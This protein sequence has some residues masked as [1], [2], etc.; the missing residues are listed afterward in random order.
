MGNRN[1]NFFEVVKSGDVLTIDGK[2]SDI[3]NKEKLD[4]IAIEVNAKNQ[5]DVPV[6][7]GIYTFV[8][9]KS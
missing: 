4:V 3:K 5:N 1:L 2:I 8:V 9:R 6:S 7:K